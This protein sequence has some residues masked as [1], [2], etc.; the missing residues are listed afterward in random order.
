MGPKRFKI[1]ASRRKTARAEKAGEEAAGVGSRL[2]AT[3]NVM[4]VTPRSNRKP[5]PSDYETWLPA[6]MRKTGPAGRTF[7]LLHEPPVGPPIADPRHFNPIWTSALERF[8]PRLTVCGHDHSSPVQNGSWHTQFGNT[9]V[10]NVGQTDKNFHYTVLDVEFDG[11][12]PALPR[13]ISARAFPWNQEVIVTMERRP[14]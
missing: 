12:A 3:D 13:R 11:P 10:I 5:L 14:D 1:G 8:S 6:L 9:V 2:S 4:E 7:W